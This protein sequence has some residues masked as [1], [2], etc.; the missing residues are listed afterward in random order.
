MI[1]SLDLRLHALFESKDLIIK[2]GP[3]V[4]KGNVRI[5]LSI[6]NLYGDSFI[7]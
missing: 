6:S 2:V 7:K 4:R 5:V 1:W 3:S